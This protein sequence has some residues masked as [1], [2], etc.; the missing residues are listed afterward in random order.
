MLNWAIKPGPCTNASAI[1]K[2]HT[3]VTL[4]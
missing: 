3:E 1:I 4:S 2:I